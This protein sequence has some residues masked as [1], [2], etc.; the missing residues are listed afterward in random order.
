MF[1]L[2]WLCYLVFS[3]LIQLQLFLWC[4]S[5]SLSIYSEKALSPPLIIDWN[6]YLL[7][8]ELELNG[9]Y[10][11]VM[12]WFNNLMSREEFSSSVQSVT[13]GKGLNSFKVKSNTKGKYFSRRGNTTSLFKSCYPIFIFQQQQN[14][15]NLFTAQPKLCH[16]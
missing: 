11:K 3:C 1:F 2:S 9:K 12:A 10:S 13:E 14:L 4:F 8:L 6:N 16:K 7:N 15:P 5:G